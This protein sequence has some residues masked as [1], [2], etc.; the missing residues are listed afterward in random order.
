MRRNVL[1][2]CA[3][4]V[5]AAAPVSRAPAQAPIQTRAVTSPKEHFGFN[6]CDDYCLAN[7]KQLEAYWKM[8]EKQTD[9]MKLVNIGKTEEGRDQY[10]AVV[11][12]PAN[13]AKLDHY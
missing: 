4:A 11:S 12:S 8:I 5:L 10:M 13:L 1:F 2:L 9:R 6:I 7:Y 3:V